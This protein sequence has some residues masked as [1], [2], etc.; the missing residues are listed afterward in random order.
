MLE[1]G[2]FSQFAEFKGTML[3]PQRKMKQTDRLVFCSALP[4]LVPLPPHGVQKVSSVS[5]WF[6]FTFSSVIAMNIKINC[7]LLAL[8]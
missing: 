4:R 2:F 3:L 7:F 5:G 1:T 8:K 6:F